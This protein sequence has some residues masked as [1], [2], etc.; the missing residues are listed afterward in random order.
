MSEGFYQSPLHRLSGIRDAATLTGDHMHILLDAVTVLE[1]AIRAGAEPWAEYYYSE[2][3]SK[4]TRFGY[5]ALLDGVKAT[6]A[7]ILG[8]EP[9]PPSSAT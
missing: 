8:T 5:L 2:A 1:A 9:P 4:S 7:A 6:L 3:D